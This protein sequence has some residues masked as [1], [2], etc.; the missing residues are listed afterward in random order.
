[1]IDKLPMKKIIVIITL[2]ISF[3]F[4][5]CGDGNT[6]GTGNNVTPDDNISV[7]D[8]SENENNDELLDELEQQMEELEDS[9][10]KQ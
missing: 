9:T 8:T 5:A 7:I 1:M 2:L 10:K 6:D 3:G 4:Y